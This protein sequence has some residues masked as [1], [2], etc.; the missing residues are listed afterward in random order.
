M[1]DCSPRVSYENYQRTEYFGAFDGLR[2][3]SITAVVWH[4]STPRQ[5]E[6][7]LGRGHLG[8][9]LFFAISGF[10][11]TSLLL[12]EVA[13]SGSVRLGAFWLRRSVRL[14]PLYYLVL[15]GF[16]VRALFLP[17]GLPQREHFLHNF[18]FFL[19]HTGN[20]FVD[21]GVT[22]PILFAFGWSLSTEQQ[23]YAI[24]PLL[25][26]LVHS[27]RYPIAAGSLLLLM[28]IGVDQLA[29]RQ[30]LQPVLTPGSVEF[31]IVTS[32]VASIA[33]GALAALLLG[34]RSTFRWL[35]PALGHPLTCVGLLAGGALWVVWPPEHFVLFECLLGAFVAACAL[36][37]GPIPR[38]LSAPGLRHIG[39]V[40]YGMYLFHVPII[41]VLKKLLPEPE[42]HTLL[43]FGLAFATS[44]A[45]AT[46][47]E[48]YFETPV[49][50]WG[51]RFNRPRQSPDYV[52]A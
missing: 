29:E 50:R 48:R 37:H 10:L 30:L 20:W 42:S 12:R 33:F 25:L 22:H 19:T 1:S 43:L 13:R 27:L 52:G 21:Y 17:E 28:M 38:L 41:G 11:I 5:L 24:W 15:F 9:R 18:P 16:L 35:G 44:A 47:S 39:R 2:A 3:L 51:R 45:L 8:V 31:E 32:F 26:K 49:R 14:L 46:V 6:G 23:F 34:T 40:S 7:V 4:H 36:G